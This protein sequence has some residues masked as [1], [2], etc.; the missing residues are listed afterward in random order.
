MLYI[1]KLLCNLY[2][3]HKKDNS[4]IRSLAI[5]NIDVFLRNITLMEGGRR[6]LF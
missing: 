1:C 2:A 3:R 5:T 4:C 6:F